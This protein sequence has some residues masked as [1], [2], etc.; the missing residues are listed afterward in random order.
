[1]S[2][3]LVTGAGGFIGS[4]LAKELLRNSLNTVVTIDNFKTGFKK[5]VPKGTILVEGDCSSEKTIEKLNE[6]KFDCIFHIAGQ[7]SGEISFEDPI[8]DLNTNTKS[9]LLLLEFAKKNNCKKFIYAST[10]SVY[11]SNDKDIAFESDVLKPKSFYAVGKIASENY[12]K[13]YS[14]N[15][16]KCY[17]L[18]LFNVYG[19]GQNMSNQK[20]GMVSI[21]LSQ[22]VKNKFVHIKGSKDR[23]R[24]FVYIDD[25]VSAFLKTYE[26]KIN[27]NFDVFNVSNNIK[28]S[29][30]KLIFSLK[31]HIPFEFKVNY[32]GNTPGDQFGIYGNNEKL[33]LITKWDPN[34]ILNHGIKKM[35]DWY[36]NQKK[37]N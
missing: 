10:M 9:T 5:N 29:I 16:L 2:T 36:L 18:R 20:Q 12:M 31:E 30:Y 7:S 13:I 25:V 24:D 23:F 1:M 14:S 17:A 37:Y 34:I 8:Y 4:Y 35:V 19:P 15:N 3:F 22:A 26:T 6:F 11:G 21:F 32:E 28:T 27:S 33:K